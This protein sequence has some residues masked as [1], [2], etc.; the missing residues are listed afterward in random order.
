MFLDEL[1]QLESQF[2][3]D[4]LNAR[5]KS[6]KNVE[7]KFND[8]AISNPIVVATGEVAEEGKDFAIKHKYKRKTN[9]HVA[10]KDKEC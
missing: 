8:E 3:L 1:E 10:V 6:L 2:N 7:P 5:N 4:K 9:R